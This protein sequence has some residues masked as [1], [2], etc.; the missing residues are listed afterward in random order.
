MRGGAIEDGGA[1]YVDATTRIMQTGLDTSPGKAVY[2]LVSVVV[3]SNG[4]KIT[5][6]FAPGGHPAHHTDTCEVFL[7]HD[8]TGQR[9]ALKQPQ[10]NPESL[11][12]ER[13]LRVR[14]MY[15]A[16]PLALI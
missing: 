15:S 16:Q 5:V 8:E 1:C 7:G 11:S 4:R 6:T 9:L 3:E 10:L 13:D 14:A 12:Y 2:P